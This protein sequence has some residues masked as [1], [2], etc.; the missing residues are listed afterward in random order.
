M[1]T[2][3]NVLNDA[4]VMEELTGSPRVVD[5]YSHCGGTIWVEVSSFLM[6]PL[7]TINTLSHYHRS[8]SYFRSQHWY[9]DLMLSYYIHKIQ[10]MPNEVEEIIIKQDTDGM[11]KPKDLPKELTP[12]NNYTVEEKLDLAL[13]MAESLADLHGFR[14]GVM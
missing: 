5:I 12:F 9:T 2:Y 3:W 6:R 13:S 1:D 11:M 7:F 4:L 10:G 14:D 8:L